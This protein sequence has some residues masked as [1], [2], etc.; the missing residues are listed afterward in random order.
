MKSMMINDKKFK[1]L[2][3]KLYHEDCYLKKHPSLHEID[4]PWKIRK[5]IPL[6]DQFINYNTKDEINLLDVGGGAGLILKGISL[7][8]EKK[9]GLKVNKFALDLSLGILKI[10]K[11]KNLDLKK[12]LNEDICHTSLKNKEIDLTLMID[13]LEHI[14]NPK[15][16]LE[17]LKRIS[18][19][20]LMKVPLEDNLYFKALNFIKKSNKTYNSIE[21]FGHVYF[22]NYKS[23]KRHIEKN[24]GI[25]LNYYFTNV[26][27]FLLNTPY[28][29]NKLK[30]TN[31]LI[32]L[33]FMFMCKISPKL[34]SFITPDFIMVLSKCY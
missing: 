15:M 1:D 25:V 8:I 20:V 28:Y 4:S 27:E 9:Y 31:K 32:N 14:P 24:M 10:Q 5:I 11:E 34:S 2:V 19:F 18:N 13:V 16:A 30:I 21:K 23:L 33:L 12:A 17:E 22:Y 29:R 7:Y 6:V 3:K 26:F